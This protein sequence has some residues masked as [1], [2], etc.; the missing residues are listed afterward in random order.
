MTNVA[1]L[2]EQFREKLLDLT[3]RNAL[4]NFRHSDRSLS[5]IRVIDEQPDFLWSQLMTGHELMFKPL[6]EKNDEPLDEIDNEKFILA[7][8]EAKITDTEYANELKKLEDADEK[9]QLDDDEKEIITAKIERQLKD[10]IREQLVMPPRKSFEPLTNSQWAKKKGLNPS[11]E[12]P[13]R[14][15]DENEEEKHTDEYIQTLLTPEEL[16]RKLDG[17]KSVISTDINEMGVNSFFAAFGFLQYIERTHNKKMLAPI[18]LLPLDELK[19]KKVKKKELFFTV[20]ATQ[21]PMENNKTLAIALKQYNLLLP[22]WDEENDTPESYFQK[23][24]EMVKNIPG[25]SVHRYITFGRFQFSRIIMYQDL[26]V[27]SWTKANGIDN[28]QIIKDLLYGTKQPESSPYTYDIDED[29]DVEKYAP[30]LAV[31]A[32]SSQ[33]S[34]VIEAM[35]GKSIVIK[36]PPGTGKSQTITNLIANALFKG[37]KVLFVAEKMAALDVVYNRLKNVGLGD[38]CLELHSAKTKL[39]NL[40]ENLA[41]TLIHRN[42]LHIPCDIEEKRAKLKT[43]IANLR[44][45]SSELNSEVGNTGKTLFEII[46]AEQRYRK[47]IAYLPKTLLVSNNIEYPERISAKVIDELAQELQ[48]LEFLEDKNSLFEK[49]KHPWEGINIEHFSLSKLQDVKDYF[50]VS[51]EELIKLKKKLSQIYSKYQWSFDQ[52]KEKMDFLVKQCETILQYINIE[53][54]TEIIERLQ[55]TDNRGL[56]TN[57]CQIISSY[58]SAYNTLLEKKIKPLELIEREKDFEEL[59]LTAKKYDLWDKTSAE[60]TQEIKSADEQSKTWL[61]IIQ[62]IA[63]NKKEWLEKNSTICFETLQSLIKGLSLFDDEILEKRDCLPIILDKIPMIKDAC[64]LQ[65]AII[66]EGNNLARVFDTPDDVNENMLQESISFYKNHSIFAIFTGK[67]WKN[68][69]FVSSIAKDKSVLKVPLTSLQTLQRYLI[70]KK[71]FDDKNYNMLAGDLYNGLDTDFNSILSLNETMATLQ[72]CFGVSSFIYDILKH[73]NIIFLQTLKDNSEKISTIFLS[74]QD[75]DC[76]LSNI[77]DKIKERKEFL[78]KIEKTLAFLTKEEITIDELYRDINLSLPYLKE[79]YSFF[80]EQNEKLKNILGT[81]YLRENT[82]LQKLN[83]YLEISSCYH[84]MELPIDIS[85][86]ISNSNFYQI[87]QNI[88]DDL[89]EVQ[90]L[91]SNWFSINFEEMKKIVQNDLTDYF[92]NTNLEGTDISVFYNKINTSMDHPNELNDLVEYNQFLSNIENKPYAKTLKNLKQLNYNYKNASALFL[93]GYY[94]KLCKDRLNQSEVLD[95]SL[96]YQKNH[97]DLFKKLDKEMMKINILITSGIVCSEKPPAGIAFGSPSDFTEMG[98]IKHLTERQRIRRSISLRNFMRKC[99]VSMQILKPCFLM[100]PLSVAKYLVPEKMS[101]DLLV[102][103]EASQMPVEDALGAIARAKQVVV[104]GDNNQLPPT[105]FFRNTARNDDYDDEDETIVESVLDQALQRFNPTVELTWHYRSRH[106]SLIA[107]SNE[108]FYHNNLTVFP[109][110]DNDSYDLGIKYHYI[111]NG[112][113]NERTNSKEVDAIVEYIIQHVRKHPTRTLGV[114]TMNKPQESLIRSRLRRRFQYDE[115]LEHFCLCPIKDK[116]LE[117]FF[118][119]NLENVQGDERDT[120]LISTVYGKSKEGSKVM[121]RFGPINGINGHR[122]LNV[123]F[124]RAKI[125]THVF[126]SLKPDD[127]VV[128]ANSYRGTRVFKDY[129]IY[130]A[131]GGK[132]IIPSG[133]TGVPD[134]CFEICVKD[135]LESLGYE[136]HSQVGVKGFFIDLGV[137]HPRFPYGYIAGIECDGV[138]YHSSKSARDRDIIR[139]SVL[140]GL[141]WNIYR[142]WSTDWYYNLDKEIEKLT[143]YLNRKIDERLTYIDE[144]YISSSAEAVKSIKTKAELDLSD[145]NNTYEDGN[146][147]QKNNQYSEKQYTPEKETDIYD[148]YEEDSY[149]E[150]LLTPNSTFSSKLVEIGD[151]VTISYL[152]KQGQELQYIISEHPIKNKDPFITIISPETPIAKGLLGLAEGD[153]QEIFLPRGKDFIKVIEIH[154]G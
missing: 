18:A 17:L 99:G 20:K 105:S 68:R 84:D 48:R 25:W 55:S 113:F 136:V 32:D 107:F 58:N 128:N 137:K 141:G 35:K 145:Y 1:G 65:K 54:S 33:H 93:Y 2:V 16:Q 153:E 130:A 103:D 101:F 135:K 79:G 154:K 67:Y 120:I 37:E 69:S 143:E 5:Q 88:Y 29:P 51:K 102:I 91:Y 10:K 80:T 147:H 112:F 70:D 7:L 122:R 22:E 96:H 27:K 53:I 44:K 31:D 98:L 109:S 73:E 90:R 151:L 97:T 138:P 30:I 28:I 12:L 139:Q 38:F 114:A 134:S 8:E 108:Q 6:P 76:V 133:D 72:K 71:K 124:T 106:E 50:Q 146:T 49:G 89:I 56:L 39:K 144:H 3:N 36:G 119:K 92:G 13:K 131:S 117:P 142:I 4:L 66:D 118:I 126:S 121:Q 81:E 140:E 60:L 47:E 83:E 34:A 59:I 86:K 148:A 62:L 57:L 43:A 15:V 74:S 95:S 19:L 24:Q 152:N 75:Y 150:D 11:Y 116:E 123:L 63:N 110:P 45:A 129:L 94:S 82:S 61:K 42:N 78:I 77:T 100:S 104:V 23:I 125:E 21:E 52:S 85:E 127:I 64:K 46:W 41:E 14:A 26:D 115:E 9:G 87:I 111:E 40:K 149:E 132:N